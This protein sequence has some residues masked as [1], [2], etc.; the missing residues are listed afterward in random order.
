[1]KKNCVIVLLLILLSSSVCFALEKTTHEKLNEFIATNSLNG[2][3]LDVYLRNQLGFANGIKEEFK[4]TETKKVWE[5]IKL[6]GSS[7]DEPFYTRSFNHFHN[8]L[9]SWDQAGFGGTFKSA[10]LWAQDQGSFGSLFGGNYS[11][12]AVRDYYYLGLTSSTKTEREKNLADT[13]RGLGQL[14]HL[15]EDMS[16]PAHTRNDAHVIGYHYEKAVEKIR[17]SGDE[18]M[19]KIYNDAVANPITFDPSILVLASN[20]L[21]PIPIAKI[22]D[23]DKYD[24]STAVSTLPSGTTFG[25]AEYTNANFFSEETIFKGFSHPAK[26]NTNA[27]LTEQQAKDGKLDKIWYIYKN[28]DTS[29]K[30][31][32]AYSYFWI[33]SGFIPK[34]EWLYNLDD[35]VYSDYAS[36]LL[37]RAVGYSAGL[38][39]YFFRGK[40]DLVEDVSAYRIMNLSDE[41][42]SGNIN[43]FKLFY[44]DINDNRYEI[45]LSFVDESGNQY[46]DPNT[47]LTIPAQTKSPFTIKL[48]NM[49]SAPKRLILIFYGRLG[50]EDNA[51]VGRLL[52]SGIYL[53]VMAVNHETRE[54]L[55]KQ[56]YYLDTMSNTLYPVSLNQLPFGIVDDSGYWDDVTGT[57]TKKLDPEGLGVPLGTGG[58]QYIAK[59]WDAQNNRIR[60]V[61]NTSYEKEAYQAFYIPYKDP[62]T[63]QSVK[64]IYYLTFIGSPIS[65]FGMYNENTGWM[66]YTDTGL[67][68]IQT[69]TS[70]PYARFFPL[71]QT[72][73]F[74]DT[75]IETPSFKVYNF[76][77][78]SY[79]AGIPKDPDAPTP[80]IVSAYKP[81]GADYVKV[82]I[83]TIFNYIRRGWTTIG[84]SGLDYYRFY[85]N[86]APLYEYHESKCILE[87]SNCSYLYDPSSGNSSVNSIFDIPYNHN[88]YVRVY[89]NAGSYY[90]ELYINNILRETSPIATDRLRTHYQILASYK[91]ATVIRETNFIAF[92]EIPL[93]YS[94]GAYRIYERQW[95]FTS[96]YYI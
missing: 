71:Y 83:P 80:S 30:R 32:A 84:S 36:L 49:P 67:M 95:D 65:A 15:V 66:E 39:N 78:G 55:P 77:G 75:F 42:M 20:P 16:V 12:K 8:P 58:P 89:N 73:N 35:N 46:T 50:N 90:E 6:G 51:V 94:Y 54:S 23:T 91:D 24:E 11:W 7:E 27:V 25:L 82:S 72:T 3:S 60:F 61:L 40:I 48:L 29:G 19:K 2:F 14:M 92:N 28:G 1:M 5:W 64:D 38:I 22:F 33:N 59:Y 93:S 57:W 87:D 13:F 4:L 47:T 56:F 45:P 74:N 41:E 26:E 70:D 43:S 44:D 18:T 86:S 53:I 96:R 37:P 88:N 17:T 76:N 63:G 68:T 21:A 85:S 81:Q 52:S 79:E 69:P 62:Y 10:I 31:L 34:T 9:L